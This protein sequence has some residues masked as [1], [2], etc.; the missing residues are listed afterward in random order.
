MTRVMPNIEAQGGGGELGAAPGLSSPCDVAVG[1]ATASGSSLQCAVGVRAART[2]PPADVE[3]D[4]LLRTTGFTQTNAVVMRWLSWTALDAGEPRPWGRST[5]H[6][7][8]SL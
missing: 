5:A 8:W 4:R 2:T 3:R 1:A 6:R 7:R